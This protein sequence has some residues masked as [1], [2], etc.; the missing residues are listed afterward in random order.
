M[1]EEQQSLSKQEER[2]LD[3]AEASFMRQDAEERSKEAEAK[4]EGK[5]Q[6][7]EAA[8]ELFRKQKETQKKVETSHGPV[9]PG[10]SDPR[11]KEE[12]EKYIK[13][14]ENL[15]MAQ[16]GAPDK[17]PSPKKEETPELEEE[18]GSEIEEIEEEK[19]KKQETAKENQR[20][21]AAL[22]FKQ[23][24]DLGIIKYNIRVLD[25]KIGVTFNETNPLGYVWAYVVPEGDED[26]VFLK[27]GELKDHPLIQKYHAIKEGREPLPEITVTG[28]ILE[29]RGKAL[30]IEI[31]ENGELKEIFYGQGAVKKDKDGNHF[32]PAGFSKGGKDKDGKEHDAKMDIPRD[33]QLPDY[34]AQLKQVPTA[35]AS[36]K[37]EFQKEKGKTKPTD[38]STLAD[39]V[40]PKSQQ[41]T[42][43]PPEAIDMGTG[44]Q[45]EEGPTVEELIAKYE[46]IRTLI[47]ES[48]RDNERI[49]DR[50][51]GYAINWISDKVVD[52]LEKGGGNHEEQA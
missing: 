44:T 41:T 16:E 46:H 11:L 9:S 47:T 3:D 30:R 43:P 8:D 17:T 39:V 24:N 26:K 13:Q 15:G 45:I 38:K 49:S 2:E 34:L 33:I 50:E 28:K 14:L 23:Y 35:D 27:N 48:V 21:L 40:V 12:E 7:F 19:P 1:S 32:I 31:E 5:E 36:K 22:G 51:K 52:A 25:V 37:E 20:I 10:S 4:K 42:P 6:E 18:F 29:K